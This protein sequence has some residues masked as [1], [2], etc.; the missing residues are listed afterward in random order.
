MTAMRPENDSES[1]TG[2][3]EQGH[4]P[5]SAIRPIAIA[6]ATTLAAA[7][8]SYAL[9]EAHAASGVGACFLVVVYLTVLRSPDPRK[10]AESGLAL[11]GIF[12]PEPLSAKRL[13]RA[14]LGAIGWALLLALVTFPPFWLGYYVWYSPSLDFSPAAL[15]SLE[16]EVFAQLFGIAFPEEAFYRGYLQSALDRVWPPEKRVFGALV[17]PSILVTSLIFALGH[18]LT[19]PVPGRL[20]VFFPSL[21]FGFLRARSGGVGSGAVY[22]ALCNLFAAYLGKSY[23]LFR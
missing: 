1:S 18:Y 19:L 7:A 22:H 3:V 11:G 8:L 4:S 16:A 9:P 12:D 15:P 20:A 17:G 10:I 2:A 23:G 21:V 6:L 13:A 14:A 5:S